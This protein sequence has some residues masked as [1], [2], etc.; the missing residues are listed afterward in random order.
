M[1]VPDVNLLVYAY[2]SDAPLH[3]V[4]K[5]WWESSL[6]EGASVGIPWA[7]ICGFVR[8]MTHPSVLVTPLRPEKALAHVRSWLELPSV[9]TL[10]PGP[11][12]LEIFDTLVRS[13]GVAANLTTDT[14]LAALSI[15]YG[16]ELHSNDTDFS[17]FPGLR[18][19]NPLEKRRAVR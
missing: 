13:T 1:I 10:D 2:N 11:R 18:W 15:E 3:R 12:H 9:Q 16:C 7:V 4:S 19:R 17:R 6:N 14:H 5:L 8:L